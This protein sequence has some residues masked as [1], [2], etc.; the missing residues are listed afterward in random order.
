MVYNGY[1]KHPHIVWLQKH[2]FTMLYH[3][4]EDEAIRQLVEVA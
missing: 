1:Y 3:F 2:G 4:R